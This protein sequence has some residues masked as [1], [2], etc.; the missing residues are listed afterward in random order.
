MDLFELEQQRQTLEASLQKLRQ[1]LKHWQ[2]WEAEYEGL[3]EDVSSLDEEPSATQ[4]DDVAK[5]Y[6]GELVNQKEI[7][8]L[9]GLDKDSPRHTKQIIGLIERRQE[10]VQ[11]NIE[12]VQRQFFEAEA[13]SEEL[14]FAAR[15]QS[16]ATEAGLP[17]TEI[18]EEL[19]EDD[20]VVSSRLS[21]PEESTAN[22]IDSLRQAGLK[23]GDV[24]GINPP[25][26]KPEDLKPA[27]TNV[28]PPITPSAVGFDKRGTSDTSASRT[29]SGGAEDLERP[30]IR[31]KSVSFTA[32]TKPPEERQRLPSEDGRKSVSFAE[33]VAVMP[34]AP[35]AD[36]RSVSFS[37]MVEEIPPQPL[38]PPSPAMQPQP[39]SNDQPSSNESA[40]VEPTSGDQTSN[41]DIDNEDIVVPDDESPEDART[42]REMLE[43]HLN[44]VGSVVAQMDL[45]EADM[46]LDEDDEDEDDEDDDGSSYYTT[47]EYPEDESSPYTTGLSE[48]EESEDEFGR[49]KH[50]MITPE[51]SRKME[52]MQ[53]RMI[54]NVG[55]A[56]KDADL[57]DTDA[58][59]DSKDAAR[60]AIREKRNSTSSA[61][62]DNSEKKAGGKK[63]VSFADSLD[64]AEPGS[65]PLKAQKMQESENVAPMTTSIMERTTATSHSLPQRPGNEK[66]S[67]FKKERA[68]PITHGEDEE[69]ATDRAMDNDT[70]DVP[71][72][73]PGVTIAKT[74]TERVH[75]TKPATAPSLDGHDATMDQ[76]ELA[77]EY[78]RQRND[79]IKQQGGFQSSLNDDEEL[80]E[81][82]E[83]RDGK[84]KKVS[85][86][87]AARIKPQ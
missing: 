61:S 29:S 32:D 55:P 21:Q 27:I 20:N 66:P 62:S 76:R 16:A 59:L 3:K 53:Q 63:R 34:S 47:S 9:S 15:N 72:G 85:R 71:T 19:D 52:E 6:D 43:Y 65:P 60:L 26:P 35:P 83:E 51:Y 74:L 46:K 67:R 84:L 68:A 82:M 36:T 39:Q 73:P 23:E 12:T 4:L 48:S 69:A 40:I 75:P 28:S 24:N 22:F 13:K 30:S 5:S 7:R 78:Y 79:I 14:A 42:R 64:V 1:S 8:D 45:D 58:Q 38:G 77:T 33:K 50:G 57:A 2:T 86:F 31:K 87:K 81:L 18:H 80:G 70:D 25:K 41:G 54:S 11:K 37:P 10:Y 56:P 17:L 49:A 44:E